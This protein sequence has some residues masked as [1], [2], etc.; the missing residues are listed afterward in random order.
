MPT[1]NRGIEAKALAE[2]AV[3]VQKIALISGIL[4]A[5]SDAAQDIR[6]ALNKLA[7][8]VPPGAVSQGLMSSSAQNTMMQQKQQQPQIAAQRAANPVMPPPQPGAPPP[9]A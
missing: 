9:A 3:A 6:E 1:P 2:L 5:G 4:P 8:H 7:K